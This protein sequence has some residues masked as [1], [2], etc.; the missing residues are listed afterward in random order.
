MTNVG[1]RGAMTGH[2]TVLSCTSR[3]QPLT[4]TSV[5]NMMHLAVLMRYHSLCSKMLLPLTSSPTAAIFC[6]KLV[7]GAGLGVQRRATHSCVLLTTGWRHATA[8]DPLGST[9]TTTTTTG[10][11]EQQPAGSSLNQFYI[12]A[13]R[14]SCLFVTSSLCLVRRR[15]ASS[16]SSSGIALISLYATATTADRQPAWLGDRQGSSSA[17]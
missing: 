11:D 12:L 16:N 9:T 4:P 3:W 8:A 5:H 7:N 6:H 10:S 1:K 2:V 13:V 15:A 14:P 17:R